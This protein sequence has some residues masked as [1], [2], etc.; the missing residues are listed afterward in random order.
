MQ[1]HNSNIRQEVLASKGQRVINYLIDLIPQYAIMYGIAYGFFYIGEFTGYYGLSDF[2][3]G[4]SVIEDYLFS[5]TLLF[6]YYLIFEITT[7]R[8][9]GKYVTNTK[10]VMTSGQKPSHK[11][12]AIRSLCRLIPF[13]A[14]SFLGTNGKGWHDSISDTYVVDVKKFESR[15]TSDFELDQIGVPTD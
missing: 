4:L 6:L 5:F 13:D 15:K 7:Q 2:W 1:L 10:V 3:S 9:L 8:S 12:I 14:L 11:A